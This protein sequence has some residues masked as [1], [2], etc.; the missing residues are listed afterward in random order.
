MQDTD[1]IHHITLK[2][3]NKIIQC[4]RYN[5]PRKYREAWDALLNQHIAAGRLRP[6]SSSFVSLAFLI[7]KKDPTALLRWVNN[8]HALNANTVPDNHPLPCIN[9][10]LCDCTKGK[11]FSKIDTTNLF[12][13]T[14]IHPD[15]IKYMVIDTPQG[16]HE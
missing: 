10:I 12:F 6:S 4:R 3:P 5:M 2:D 1:I 16:L 9:E 15:N 13:Q 14:Q 11:I 7:P 8:Y